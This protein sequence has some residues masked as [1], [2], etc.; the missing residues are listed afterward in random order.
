[1]IISQSKAFEK[2]KKKL[3][4]KQINELDKI[5]KKI[6]TNSSIGEQKKGELQN[7][8]VF[9]FKLFNQEYLLA[10][11]IS[12]NT[13]NLLSLGTHENFYRNLKKTL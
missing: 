11:L 6:I 4:P 12:K 5:I 2:Q 8:R 9:K 3:F 13:L 1:L 7:I 10:Y